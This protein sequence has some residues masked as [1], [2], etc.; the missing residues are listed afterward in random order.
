MEIRSNIRDVFPGLRTAQKKPEWRNPKSDYPLM[1]SINAN[2]DLYWQICKDTLCAVQ[3]HGWSMSTNTNTPDCVQNIPALKLKV[4]ME[5]EMSIFTLLSICAPLSLT[6]VNHPFYHICSSTA[7]K[8]LQFCVYTA[9]SVGTPT[10]FMS[11]FNLTLP[12][13]P[14]YL[15]WKSKH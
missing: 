6:L 1:C 13:N 12:D 14:H 9:F 2:T 10:H 5:I 7:D 8:N 4:M 15:N 11:N 3:H